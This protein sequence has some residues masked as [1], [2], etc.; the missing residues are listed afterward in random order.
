M[1]DPTELFRNAWMTHS[2]HCDFSPHPTPTEPDRAL[3]SQTVSASSKVRCNT[4]NIIIIIFP[5]PGKMCHRSI[6]HPLV[7]LQGSTPKMSDVE[8]LAGPGVQLNA[9]GSYTPNPASVIVSVVFSLIFLLGT[10]GNSLVLAVLLRSGQVGYNTTNLFILNL[11]MADFFFI[12]FCVPFQATIYSLDGWV[13]GSFMCK[14]VHFFIN[15][16]MYA[17]SFTL[18]AVS[19][20]RYLAIR[21]PLRSRE[22]RT[23]CN[24]VVAMVIIWGLSL[25]FAGPYLSYYHLIDFANSTVCIPGW[26]ERDRKLL[27]TCTFLFGYVIPVLIVSL[28]YTRTIKYLWTA[29][30]P[31]DGMSE[32]K[33]AKR[34]VTKMIIIVTVLF[35]ICWLPY[36]VVILCYLYGDFPFNRVTY[37]FRLLSHCMAYANSCV[38]PIVYALVS[39]HFRKGFKKVFSCLLSNNRRNKVHV[40][41]VANTVPGF[42]AAST[43]VSQMNEENARQNEC[44][45][46]N[47]RPVEPREPTV[48]LNLPF[49]H[50]T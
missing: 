3:S 4:S 22:L 17:S 23:P 16:T 29:V 46:T 34:K 44:E 49:Q 32:S 1:Y 37:A 28:S 42:E 35:C 33:R 43:E 50:P 25:V 21:Y 14:A 7:F 30:D 45:M 26:E 27:D 36:H 48:T 38:N 9:S 15:L 31:L 18:A 12:I 39:K 47:R 24:A 6:P 41:H 11:S 2:H 13:F 19:V 40:V 5:R 10:V 20:D 8:D